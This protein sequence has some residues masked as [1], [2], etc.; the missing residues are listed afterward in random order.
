MANKVSL[1]AMQ[2]D[3][4][5]ELFNLGVGKAAASL[6]EIV[7]QEILLSVPKVSFQTAAALIDMLG[8]EKKIVSIAQDIGGP[9]QAR[10]ILLF[11]E[12][13]SLVVV[14]QMLGEHIPEELLPELQEEALTEIGNV[15]LNACIGAIS[16]T[17]NKTFCVDIP[18]FQQAG[19]EQIFSSNNLRDDN[20]ILLLEIDLTLKQSDISGYLAFIFSPDAVLNLQD[21]VNE[22]L[23]RLGAA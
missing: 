21:E 14:K 5:K 3:M 2:E 18:S 13:N 11:H 6:S 15:V 17:M 22:M 12:D 7:K 1:S 4:L 8:I 9:F 16:K 23:K 20:V 10:S 19:P